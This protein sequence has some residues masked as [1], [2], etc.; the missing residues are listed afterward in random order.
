[1]PEEVVIFVAS[2]GYL[3]IFI[4]IF[5]QE[6]GMPNPFPNELLLIFSGYLT[7]QGLLSFP[8]VI[9]TAISADFIGTNIL[10][11]IFLNTGTFIIQKKPRWLP[12]SD[13]LIEKLSAKMT[14]GGKLSIYIFRITPFTRGYA[15]VI[16]GLLQ[17]KPKVF[18]PIA[19]I[20]ATTWA[21]VYVTIGRLIGPSWNIFLQN[22]DNFKY[23][24]IGLL[25]LILCLVV[26]ISSRK[27]TIYKVNDDSNNTLT[28]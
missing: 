7:Y 8:L 22:I 3:A 20:S 26:Y 6:I 15:S 10:Y 9:I 14:K 11:F 19:F 25:V 24:M 16:T 12:L 13:K 21:I 4:L 2:Y 28:I 5:L 18:L 17:I 27:K 23:V 1:M